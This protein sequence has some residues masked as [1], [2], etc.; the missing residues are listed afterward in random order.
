MKT[1]LLLI[2]LLLTFGCLVEEGE[3]ETNNF[4]EFGEEVPNPSFLN[5]PPVVSLSIPEGDKRVPYFLEFSY[6]CYDPEDKLV[7]CN[8]SLNGELLYSWGP[9]PKD[10][11]WPPNLDVPPIRK[12]GN[13]VLTITASDEEKISSY[14]EEFFVRDTI[15]V[16]VQNLPT[17]VDETYLSAL[18]EAFSY[19][20]ERLGVNF[21]YVD[22]GEDI[23]VDWAKE[24][25]GEIV[26]RAELGGKRMIIGLGDSSC[27]GKYNFYTKDSVKAIAI[28][29]IGHLL[30]FEHVEDPND[31]MNPII[32]NIRYEMDLEESIVIPAG[33]Y[34]Y[35]GVCSSTPSNYLFEVSSS[36]ALNV[37][38][39]P[40]KEEVDN[41]IGGNTYSYI[42]G[43][44]E[45]NTN[46]F[47]KTCYIPPEAVI[48]IY[49]NGNNEAEVTLKIINKG[50]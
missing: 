35:Y 3:F 50:T 45:R 22:E 30:A 27:Y 11:E 24:Y 14:S 4:E 25:A 32:P 44:R 43:C 23:Y 12:G 8:I 1:F 46:Y 33:W 10:V 13:Y 29:E 21:V 17:G 28:H 37:Y 20:E 18:E 41:V 6:T 16:F 39:L 19:W 5:Q 26:G 2:L 49:N 38:V 31:Y 48:L 47:K 7:F 9:Y 40:N 15:K 34:F 42:E 36:R